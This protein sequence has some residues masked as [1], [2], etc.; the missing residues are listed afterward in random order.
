MKISDLYIHSSSSAPPLRVGVLLDDVVLERLFAEVVRDIRR[1]N[2]ASLELVVLN[3]AE[4]P[5]EKQPRP[6]SFASRVWRVI[7]HPQLRRA[8]AWDLY[9]RLDQRYFSTEDDPLALEDGHELLAGV[10]T[11]RVTPI[12]ERFAYR[13]PEE[14]VAA[15]RAKDLHVLLRFGFN[16][17]RG[18]ILNAARYGV[19]SFHHGDNDYYHGGPAYFWEMVEGNPLLGAELQVLTEELDASQVLAKGMFATQP[20]ISLIRNRIQP[21]WGSEHMVIQKL[22]EVREYGWERVKSGVPAAPYQGKKKIYRTPASHEMVRWLL[23]QLATKAAGRAYRKLRGAER[24]EHW[25]I[26]IR[27][28]TPPASAAPLAMDSFRW[29]ESP[30][31]HTYADPF[32]FEKDGRRHLFLEDLIY[33]ENRGVIGH[34]EISS[35]GEMG[36]VRTVLD[37]GAHASYPCVFA[38]G[39]D[40]YMI[41]ETLENGSVRLFRARRFPEEWEEVARLFRGPAV[42]TSVWKQ[43]GLWWFFTTLQEPRG[44]GM[45]LYVFWSETL[46]GRWQYHPRNPISFDVR[47]ARGAGNIFRQGEMLIRPSQD[48][49]GRYGR[50]FA[51]NR[52]V[53]LT[54]EE[55]EEELLHVV[56]PRWASGLQATHT[57]NRLGDLEVT[58]GECLR[59]RAAVW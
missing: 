32:L 10:E 59:P 20:G 4:R 23:P 28:G 8:L 19:W 46:T 30:R 25:R 12:T 22:W 27:A 36:E 53:K 37:T 44:R 40:V 43:D 49:S 42:D 6:R 1:S 38:D 21:Y 55:Y 54:R 57:Y 50:A 58:D 9:S 15:V 17:L 29:I 52:I 35:T 16:T 31:G 2:F 34:A 41:P 26:A 7:R 11:L 47:R 56:E 51:L 5:A 48:C 39:G 3:Q 14:A 33:K 13:F 24:V 18:D 45:A